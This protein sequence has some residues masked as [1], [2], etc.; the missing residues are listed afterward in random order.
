MTGNS[1]A[2][3]WPQSTKE[4]FAD[5]GGSGATFIGNFSGA[6][7]GWTPGLGGTMIDHSATYPAQLTNGD[8][9]LRTGRK[10]FLEDAGNQYLRRFAG[11]GNLELAGAG[12]FR[13]LGRSLRTTATGSAGRP[14]ADTVGAGTQMYDSG[15]KKP[16]WSDGAV[17]RDS[18]GVAV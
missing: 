10:L 1:W 3:T 16:I 8:I 6:I 2:I 7:R 17:W 11:D 9:R 5:A 13:L 12:D 14:A 18:V 15:L 4:I